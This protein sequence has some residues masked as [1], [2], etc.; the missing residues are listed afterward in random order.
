MKAMGP[1]IWYDKLGLGNDKFLPK[2]MLT[3]IIGAKCL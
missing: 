2:P 1:H 3:K